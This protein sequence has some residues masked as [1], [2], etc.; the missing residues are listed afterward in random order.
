MIDNFQRQRGGDAKKSIESAAADVE[1]GM[2]FPI[3]VFLLQRGRNKIMRKMMVVLV[4]LALC[5]WV[6]MPPIG[7][8][9]LHVE[10]FEG[11]VLSDLWRTSGGHNDRYDSVS[12][13]GGQL[14]LRGKEGSE[15]LAVS[16]TE[17]FEENYAFRIVFEMDI[18]ENIDE[19][20]NR[21]WISWDGGD[22]LWYNEYP[23]QILFTPGL[24][25]KAYW[26]GGIRIASNFDESL[27]EL[28]NMSYDFPAGGIAVFD[29]V[30]ATRNEADFTII[31]RDGE[32]TTIMHEE[33]SDFFFSTGSGR[34]HFNTWMIEK[35]IRI[36]YVAVGETLE[37]VEGIEP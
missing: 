37:D 8:E 21:F 10:R 20:I 25:E 13:E 30:I 15:L 29:V 11:K 19:V 31:V 18:P 2:R 36:K 12:V 33:F 9:V 34:L 27:G 26:S 5:L 23:Y 16:T 32:G 7:A 22:S 6:F 3:I 35:D 4:T 14:I 24:V 1:L 28:T 17:V